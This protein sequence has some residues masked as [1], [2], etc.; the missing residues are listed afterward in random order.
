[1][2]KDFQGEQMPD[3]VAIPAS[4]ALTESVER[5]L[6]A[7]E[8]RDR[9]AAAAYIELVDHLTERLINLFLVEP[10]ELTGI[11]GARKRAVD[12]AASTASKAS[13]MLTRQI[14]RK[15]SP[16]ELEPVARN[17]REIFWPAEEANG[18]FNCIAFPVTPEYAERFRRAIQVCDEGNGSADMELVASVMDELADGIIEYFFVRNSRE[19]KIGYVIQKAL[20]A[21]V[22]T[23][24]KAVH[25]VNH[26][27]LRDLDNKALKHFM[28]RHR[29]LIRQRD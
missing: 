14:Y 15:R 12:F 24:L 19:V 3:V 25:A 9:N 1:M 23:T 18:Q 28:G 5:F 6:T 21:G 8:Q 17:V 26:R 29:D 27:V 7:V 4:D 10:A 16:E 20:N 2:Q 13:H 22:D 11:T